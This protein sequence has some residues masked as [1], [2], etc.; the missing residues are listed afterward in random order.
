MKEGGEDKAAYEAGFLDSRAGAPSRLLFRRNWYTHVNRH[1]QGRI[2]QEL[3]DLTGQHV[4]YVGCGEGAVAAKEIA[5]RG[6]D[7]WCMDISTRSLAQLRQYP[8][9]KPQSRIHPVAA[10]AE[11]MPFQGRFFN[12]AVGKSIVPHLDITPFMHALRRVCA[13]NA[14]IVFAEPPGTNPIIN[15]FGS[16]TPELRVPAEHPPRTA[17]LR[18]I[19]A[20]CQSVRFNYGEFLS[21]AS[22]PWFVLGLRRVGGFLHRALGVAESTVFRRRGG[23]HGP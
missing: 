14:R 8:F 7:V 11:H 5:Q 16:L 6:A 10:D 9:S 18:L 13:G 21:M 15:L 19:R 22:Y 17:G 12:V 3:G 23:W 1:L 20:Q 2:M 4:L